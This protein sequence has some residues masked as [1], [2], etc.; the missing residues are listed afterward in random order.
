MIIGVQSSCLAQPQHVLSQVFSSWLHLFDLD[1]LN[2]IDKVDFSMVHDF[3]VQDFSMDH[4]TSRLK[5]FLSCRPIVAMNLYT[6]L[7][8][9]FSITNMT[10][11]RGIKVFLGLAGSMHIF[12]ILD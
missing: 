12:E 9:K 2:P 3:M 11:T 5:N 7:L 6:L 4:D 8:E 1:K 10:F